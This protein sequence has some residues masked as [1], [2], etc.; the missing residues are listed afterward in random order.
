MKRSG[1]VAK[2]LGAGMI[3]VAPYLSSGEISKKSEDTGV[4]KAEAHYAESPKEKEL[5]SAKE[6]IGRY[7]T[8]LKDQLEGINK[9]C[10]EGLERIRESYL[11]DLTRKGEREQAAGLLHEYLRTEDE[12][13]KIREGD[14]FDS[15]EVPEEVYRW[16]RRPSIETQGENQKRLGRTLD[17]FNYLKKNLEKKKKEYTRDGRI[18]EA[19]EFD[20]ELSSV[21]ID[22]SYN[23][24]IE[25]A[26]QQKELLVKNQQ[27]EDLDQEGKD[28]KDEKTIFEKK[29]HIVE[30]ITPGGGKA[31]GEII[32]AGLATENGGWARIAFD[33]TGLEELTKK[34]KLYVEITVSEGKF[35]R[36]GDSGIVS[37]VNGEEVIMVGGRKVIEAGVQ[38]I[39]V[40]KNRI[41][42][43]LINNP[44]LD[45]DLRV[46]VENTDN[47]PHLDQLGFKSSEAEGP[48]LILEE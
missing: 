28:I 2:V 12:I 19:I 39:K 48:R 38:R 25:L 4:L 46:S 14:S 7:R 18:E 40:D 47:S 1:L 9:E 24:S 3:L 44:N 27:E 29:P 45:F 8:I 10:Q 43:V 26:K 21:L 34:G 22:H 30:E 42:K 17:I 33:R 36:T 23:E 37:L 31:G 16:R 35:G 5:I 11:A 13:K 32:N 41:Y 20:K 6:Q 15:Q